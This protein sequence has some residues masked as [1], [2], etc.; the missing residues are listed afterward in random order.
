M[1]R[2]KHRN[3]D[4]HHRVPDFKMVYCGPKKRMVEASIATDEDVAAVNKLKPKVK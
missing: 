4:W 2:R 1:G 3:G